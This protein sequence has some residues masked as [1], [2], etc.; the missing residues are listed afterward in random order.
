MWSKKIHLLGDKSRVGLQELSKSSLFAVTVAEFNP[1]ESK[2]ETLILK[3]IITF[4]A[5]K[6]NSREYWTFSKLIP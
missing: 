6:E 4:S 3:G 1:V 5:Y 2:Q